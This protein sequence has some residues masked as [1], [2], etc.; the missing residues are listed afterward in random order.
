[1]RQINVDE[2]RQAIKEM[3]IE[4]NTRLPADI[5]EALEQ[6]KEKES[7]PRARKILEI[8]LE[9]AALAVSEGMALCQDTG[10][11]VVDTL[12]PRGGSIHSADEF[13]CANSLVERAKLSALILLR[14]AQQGW[15]R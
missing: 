12:G 13:L 2:I 11:A 10:L 7:F 15:V 9:N 14:V 8:C 6:A 5:Q 1:M 3:V 4:A